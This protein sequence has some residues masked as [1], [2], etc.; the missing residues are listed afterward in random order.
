MMSSANPAIPK[1][2][3]GGRNR[4]RSLYR[5]VEG[6]GAFPMPGL[7]ILKYESLSAGGVMTRCP[8][9]FNCLFSVAAI[10]LLVPIEILACQGKQVLFEDNFTNADNWKGWNADSKA[11]IGNGK[12]TVDVA[13]SADY[14]L[15]QKDVFD[16]IDYCVTVAITSNSEQSATGLIFWAKD[17]ANL[18]LF[19]VVP[20]AG[21]ARVSRLVASRWIY[22]TDFVEV[23]SIKKGGGA[24]TLR[25]VSK[26]AD[27]VFYVNG[28][29]ID[30]GKFPGHPAEGGSQIGLYAGT[31]KYEFSSLKMTKPE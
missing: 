28:Q 22:P 21:K 4:F 27:A 23:P 16:D 11:V 13:S 9:M 7:S 29:K 19:Q 26:G 2:K 1:G 10:L 5:R 31:G 12:M 8:L 18:Y 24:I 20:L 6:V 3:P 14:A 15:Y 25:V 30:F 17:I